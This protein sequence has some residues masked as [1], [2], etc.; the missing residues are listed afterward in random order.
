M[1]GAASGQAEFAKATGLGPATR[2]GYALLPEDARADNPSL[3]AH[4]Q[5]CLPLDENFWA[6]SEDKLDARFA[7]WL[8]K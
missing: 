6:E 1:G 2:Q 4:L 7:S 3:P 8:G 5:S